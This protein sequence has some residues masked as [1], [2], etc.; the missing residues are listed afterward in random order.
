MARFYARIPKTRGTRTKEGV[1]QKKKFKQEREKAESC[2]SESP[3]ADGQEQEGRTEHSQAGGSLEPWMF[4]QQFSFE[5]SILKMQ[6]MQSPF[7]MPRV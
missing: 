3:I 1:S 4:S 2:E 7:T 5:F 6:K